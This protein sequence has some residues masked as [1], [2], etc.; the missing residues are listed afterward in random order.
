MCGGTSRI[1]VVMGCVVH[2]R[3]GLS[4]RVADASPAPESR[5]LSPRVRGNRSAGSINRFVASIASTV[6]PRVCGGTCGLVCWMVLQTQG[7]SPRV[8]GNPI[9]TIGNNAAYW[10][11][12]IPACA[13][14]PGRPLRSAI[15]GSIPACAGEPRSRCALEAGLSPRVR[16]NPIWLARSPD[17]YEGLSPRVR[18]NLD[19]QPACIP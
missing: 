18:G 17:T 16:G 5:G 4:P 9:C 13:G 3:T 8:R 1:H 7:L 11:R 6:Y 10:L 15:S 12:S 19:R 14:E 2:R